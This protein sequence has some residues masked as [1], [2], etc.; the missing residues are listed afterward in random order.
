MNLQPT[1]IRIGLRR[2]IWRV[3]V[4]DTFYADYRSE[5]HAVDSAEA[6]ASALRARGRIAQV[7]PLVKVEPK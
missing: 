5:R 4:D 1:T 3:I 2:R 6:A 7:L